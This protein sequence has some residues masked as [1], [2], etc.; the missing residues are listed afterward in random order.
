M[1]KCRIISGGRKFSGKIVFLP[2]IT[3]TPSAEDLAIPL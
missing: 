2:R 1:L 3:L